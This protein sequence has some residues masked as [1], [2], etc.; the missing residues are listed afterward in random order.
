LEADLGF[1]F[2]TSRIIEFLNP[3]LARLS[4]SNI[5][6]DLRDSML[7]ELDFTKESR[8]LQNFRSFLERNS[9]V[10]ACAPKPFPEA[11]SKRVLTMEYLKGVPLVDLE[12][13]K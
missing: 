13:I 9:I 2:I 7:D 8:N 1:L 10:D 4:F 3:S 5:V 11:T 6:G 12:G